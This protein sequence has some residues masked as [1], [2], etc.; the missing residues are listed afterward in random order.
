MVEGVK[1]VEGSSF[2][3]VFVLRHRVM[4]S[5]LMTLELSIQ[6]HT[7]DVHVNAVMGGYIFVIEAY[8]AA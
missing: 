2:L 3:S 6:V 7:S 4:M 1:S 5:V 8:L